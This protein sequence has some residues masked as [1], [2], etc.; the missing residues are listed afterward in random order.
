MKY[1]LG[2]KQFNT[3]REV[4]NYASLLLFKSEIGELITGE[5]L[6]FLIDL[7]LTYPNVKNK[8]RDNILIGVKVCKSGKNKCFK[9]LTARNTLL[10]FSIY[11]CTCETKYENCTVHINNESNDLFLVHEFIK[12]F[13]LAGRKAIESQIRDFRIKNKKYFKGIK[14]LQ[15]DHIYPI[16]YAKIVYDYLNEHLTKDWRDIK[17]VK[18]KFYYF[19]DS[20]SFRDY[21]KKVAKLRI[22]TK[23]ENLR[24]P[25]PKL[26]WERLINKLLEN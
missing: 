26:D 5:D 18:N 11:K 9:V 6:T 22:L 12:S 20:K 7:F 16:T 19:S 23:K 3:K 2:T 4:Y 17:F 21:H 13:K 14:H 1:K 24:Q 25:N 15:V 8:I 10:K